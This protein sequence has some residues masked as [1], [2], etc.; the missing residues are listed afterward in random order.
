MMSE[1]QFRNTFSRREALRLALLG[2][3]ALFLGSSTRAARADY[4]PVSYEEQRRFGIYP[5]V[6]PPLPY[7]Y[8]ALERSI[9]ARTMRLASRQT[10]PNLR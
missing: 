1:D 9:D 6:L 8:N 5:Y 4:T 7:A 2:T 10:S 3:G